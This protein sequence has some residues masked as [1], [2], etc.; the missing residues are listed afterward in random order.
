VAERR[1]RA[2][3]QR[4]QDESRLPRRTLQIDGKKATTSPR[5]YDT[6]LH[7]LDEEET[8]QA[9]FAAAREIAGLLE[10]WE[11]SGLCW[12]VDEVTS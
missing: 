2:T 5:G 9:P 12:S 8:Y 4:H 3:R 10:E 7:F 1:P 6:V 11:W